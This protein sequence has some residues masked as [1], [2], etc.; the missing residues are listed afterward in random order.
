LLIIYLVTIIYSL[1]IAIFLLQKYALPQQ[2][3]IFLLCMKSQVVTSHRRVVFREGNTRNI[4][5][6]LY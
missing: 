5:T 3:A 4:N 6:F 2:K 1:H